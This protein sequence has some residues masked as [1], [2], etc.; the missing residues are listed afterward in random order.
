M[1]LVQLFGYISA[2]FAGIYLLFYCYRPSSLGKSFI[3]TS[4]IA[5]LCIGS[6]LAGGP[7][8]LSLALGFCAVGDFFLSRESEASFMAGVAAF[9]LGHLVYIAAFL[10]HPLAAPDQILGRAHI[11]IV[12]GITILAIAM[13]FILFPRAGKLAG[14]VLLY[15]PIIAGMAIASLSL[16]MLIWVIPGALVFLVSDFILSFE[17]FVLAKNAKL[18]KFT[19]FAVW[20]TYWLAQAFLLFGL[21]LPAG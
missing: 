13:A 6:M 5:A 10:T 4:S 12:L 3:K 19:P 16:P 14:P 17:L 20:S 1:P 8:W 15:I 2:G 9:A 21:V 11:G 18:R 7:I